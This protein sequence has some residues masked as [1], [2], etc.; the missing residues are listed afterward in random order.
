MIDFI[1][2]AVSAFL[3]VVVPVQLLTQRARHGLGRFVGME[4]NPRWYWTLISI[5]VA[6][7]V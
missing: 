7:G 2:G 5:Q 4:E 3:I 1:L 6:T